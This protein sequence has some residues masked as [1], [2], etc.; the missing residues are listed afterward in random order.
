M[1]DIKTWFYRIRSVQFH[2]TGL[3]IIK[4]IKTSLYDSVFQTSNKPRLKSQSH[5]IQ[6]KISDKNVKWPYKERKTAKFHF[7]GY[8]SHWLCGECT[9]IVKMAIQVRNHW[10]EYQNHPKNMKVPFIY[11]IQFFGQKP[12]KR[13]M[14]TDGGLME[15]LN[16]MIKQ[17]SESSTKS[18]EEKH[19]IHQ[20]IK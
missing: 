15:R 5:Q 8:V 10:F 19:K 1:L 4:S 7:R 11:R 9:K 17:K 3:P 16:K 13:E 20:M 6:K 18:G 2:Y 14:E 12:C